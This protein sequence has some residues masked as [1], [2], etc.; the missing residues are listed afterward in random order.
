[1]H[2]IMPKHEKTPFRKILAINLKRVLF[3]SSV[4]Q[5]RAHSTLAWGRGS[6]GPV[7]QRD[8]CDI[9]ISRKVVTISRLL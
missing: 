3:L 4:P 6:V 1:M 5:A 9:G 2:N 7:R 8:P